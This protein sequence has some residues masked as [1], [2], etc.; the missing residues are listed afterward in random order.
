MLDGNDLKSI[1]KNAG[2][3]QTEMAKKLDC[4]RKTVINYEQGVCEP[5]TSQLFRWLNV[6][7]IDLKPLAIQI[8]NFKE[9]IFLLF[10]IPLLPVVVISNVYSG[11]IV[12]C[13]L[14][15]LIRK[16]TNIIQMSIMFLVIYNFEHRLIRLL[17]PKLQDLGLS[18]ISIA[19]IHYSFQITMSLLALSL[20]SFRVKITK[21]I[22]KN[23]KVSLTI[24]D[25]ITPWIYIY[26]TCLAILAAIEYMV[27]Y[28][29]NFTHL[30]FI[31]DYYEELNYAAMLVIIWLMLTMVVSHEKSLNKQP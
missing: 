27:N 22:H 24:F 14:Y 25:K 10:T 23:T 4:D 11:L 17:S 16:T 30:S 28:M 15:G 29:Y 12:I 31:Y 8:R 18:A 2:I 1:R 9:S 26:L 19:T 20:F 6:C 13:T 3:S 5:K 7:K 21:S